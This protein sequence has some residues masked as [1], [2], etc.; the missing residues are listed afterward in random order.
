MT[1]KVL[2]SRHVMLGIL[3]VLL[4]IAYG[5]QSGGEMMFDDDHQIIHVSSFT[6][7]SDAFSVDFLGFFRPVKNLIF[8]TWSSFLPD[9]YQVWRLSAV[10]LFLGLIPIVYCFF[11]LFW[12]ES[13][14]LQI[15]CTALWACSPALTTVVSWISSTNILI[16]GYGFFLYFIFYEKS[17]ALDQVGQPNRAYFWKF[18][19]LLMFALACFSYEASVT[20]P[21][22]LGLKEFVLNRDRLK[23]RRNWLFYALSVLVLGLY[24]ILR[25]IHGGVATFDIATTIPSE[26][27]FWVSLCSGWMYL[28]HAI[29]WLWPFGQQ[30]ILIMFNPDNHKVLVVAAAIFV[31]SLGLLTLIFRNKAPK[32]FLGIAWFALALFPMANVIPLRNGPIADYYLFLPSVGLAIFFGWLFEQ[33]AT[34][35]NPRVIS[36]VGLGLAL[37][38]CGTTFLWTPNWKSQRALAEKTVAWQSENFV[39][40]ESLAKVELEEGNFAKA[41][42][43]LDRGLALAPWY[44]RLHYYKVMLFIDQK[45]VE[46]ATDLLTLL[47]EKQAMSP[48][49]FVFQAYVKEKLLGQYREAEA[50]L[51]TALDKAWDDRYSKMGAMNLAALY[52]KTDRKEFALKVYRTLSNRYPLD[53]EI[54]HKYQSLQKSIGSPAFTS[55]NTKEEL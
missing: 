20:A 25:K 15:F 16:G 49:P 2:L 22:L 13:P 17:Y 26:S 40:L 51:S 31:A 33:L 39:I 55:S 45:R 24:L 12:K 8:Y 34:K 3:I 4:G 6:S 10:A 21:V 19:A 44:S 9:Q 14:Y 30:G 53:P 52:V 38:Y 36:G 41:E 23:D 50:L 32:Q 43:Y 29:R 47:M 27:D 46:E 5:T 11:G 7:F 42:H 18:C 1:T 54:K 37:V 28:Y 35:Y 48:K